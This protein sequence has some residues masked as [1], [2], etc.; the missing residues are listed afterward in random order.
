MGA[1]EVEIATRCL[2]A[3]G[4]SLET[5]ERDPVYAF[6]ADD[7]EWVVPARPLHGIDEVRNELIWGLPPENLDAEV[8]LGDV[9]DLGEGRVRCD[10]REVYR[11]KQTGELAHERL[12][13][14]EVTIRNGKVS[15]WE[16]RVVG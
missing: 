7:V 6:L 9:E 2:Q 10:V 15:R 3:A 1:E 14:I 16:M 11:W 5:G 8:K 12:R 13:R 4:A